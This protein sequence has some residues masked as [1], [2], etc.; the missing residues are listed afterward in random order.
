MYILLRRREAPSWKELALADHLRIRR[1]GTLP[2]SRVEVDPASDKVEP[3]GSHP[4][5]PGVLMQ[6]RRRIGTLLEK[7]GM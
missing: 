2:Q 7:D 4:Y 6:Q 1:S 5:D 3:T